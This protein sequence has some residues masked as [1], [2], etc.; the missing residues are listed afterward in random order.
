MVDGVTSAT[1]GAPPRASNGGPAVFR[2]ASQV[3]LL[4][5]PL[6]AAEEH[7]L[8]VVG[9]A[10]VS[11]AAGLREQLLAA[12]TV[13]PP[14]LR[15]E[16]GSLDFCDLH[17]LDALHDAAAAAHDAGVPLTLSGM[18]TQL[19]WLHQTF[20]PAR[21]PGLD[22][23]VGCSAT[24]RGPVVPVVEHPTG[25]CTRCRCWT[26][27]A[28]RCAAPASS[29]PG[30]PGTPPAPTAARTAPCCSTAPQ[31]GHEGHDDDQAAGPPPATRDPTR[32]T[33]CTYMSR[34]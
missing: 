8:V 7:V 13:R 24:A 5:M 16:L 27:P 22:G 3:W 28:A 25:S 31:R 6:R 15:V 14:G 10:D 33:P 34:G 18:S 4:V 12:I 17:G 23:P 11:T 26:P 29:F 30:Q 20:P 9:E 19:S 2:K 1:V 21:Q 32:G